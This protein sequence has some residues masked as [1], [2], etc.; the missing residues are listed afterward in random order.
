MRSFLERGV[1]RRVKPSMW[2]V[3]DA[4]YREVSQVGRNPKRS[5]GDVIDIET[6]TTSS[7]VNIPEG[8]SILPVKNGGEFLSFG[9]EGYAELWAVNG[10]YLGKVPDINGRPLVVSRGYCSII[11]WTDTGQILR[12]RYEAKILGIVSIGV[13]D[14]PDAKSIQA[15]SRD[16]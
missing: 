14:C 12:A 10:A 8:R 4:E 2:V 15:T 16:K 3:R 5:V 6:K 11:I 9:T 7:E 13:G 1:L